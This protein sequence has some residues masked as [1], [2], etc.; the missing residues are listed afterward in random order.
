M[1]RLTRQEVTSEEARPSVESMRSTFANFQKVGE[2]FSQS[3][4][5]GESN[6]ASGSDL[7]APVVLGPSSLGVV[8][9]GGAFPADGLIGP[10]VLGP[11]SLGLVSLGLVSLGCVL[12]G[13][14]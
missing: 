13:A 4:G 8:A 3:S 5:A 9:V 2:P 12:F 7:I 14:G 10:G 11:F 6:V 1:P